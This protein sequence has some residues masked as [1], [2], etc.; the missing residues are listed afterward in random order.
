MNQ[1]ESLH[2][3]AASVA[4]P[5]YVRHPRLIG[6]VR[7]IAALTKPDRI[8]WCDGSDEEYERLCAQMVASGTLHKL[9]PAK[10]PGSYLAR[11]DPSDVA[12]V[13]DRTFICSE[14][15]ADAGPTN[16]W[17]APAEM[18]ATLDRAV[19][20][21]DARTHDVCRSVLDGADRQPD[22]AH[23]RRADG[24]PVCR[25]QHAHDDADGRAGVR[26][27]RQ[28]RTVRSLRALGGRAARARRSGRT[29]AVQQGNEIH[30]P[31]PGN[32]RDLVVRLGLRRE[33]VAREE[34][35]RA[36]DRVGDGTRRRLACRAHA[37]PRRD[38]AFRGQVPRGRR[39]PERVRQ[40]ELRDADSAEGVRGL[41]GHDDR[42]GHRLDQAASGRSL[43]RDQSGGGLL[44]RCPG[45]VVGIESERDGDAPR[46]RD[47]HERRAHR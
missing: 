39:V 30:R 28:R 1:P 32:A 21:I 13:E 11:S 29:L 47:L 6:W 25:G 46:Q 41:E 36:A 24:Q 8:V 35:L 37:D 31:L 19:R 17:R 38:D 14:R 4:A 15:E 3:L 5:A 7:E 43:P 16:N 40:D 45:H 9:N 2:S 23:R 20:R 34:M 33:R 12:R 10:R 22:R 26:R 44:R 42:R 27:A 18:R